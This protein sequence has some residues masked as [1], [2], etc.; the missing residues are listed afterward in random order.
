MEVT[1]KNS[2][3]GSVVVMQE[4]SNYALYVA[5]RRIC[6]SSD[7]KYVMAKYDEY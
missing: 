2:R 5:D 6:S 4:G 1:R 7:L 3:Y